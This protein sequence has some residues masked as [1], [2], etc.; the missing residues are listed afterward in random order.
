MFISLKSDNVNGSSCLIIWIG[1][2]EDTSLLE[3]CGKKG[4]DIVFINYNRISSR[5]HWLG[6]AAFQKIRYTDYK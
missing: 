4:L 5:N 2:I 1:G 6:T 3:E